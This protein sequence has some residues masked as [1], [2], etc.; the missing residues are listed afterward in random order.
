MNPNLRLNE[1]TDSAA[2]ANAER[3][4]LK[5]GSRKKKTQK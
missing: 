5:Y 2:V 4:S 1:K 3:R